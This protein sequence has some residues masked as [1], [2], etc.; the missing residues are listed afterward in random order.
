MV[1]EEPTAAGRE[2]SE[3]GYPARSGIGWRGGEDTEWLVPMR[4]SLSSRWSA[5]LRSKDSAS[6][7]KHEPDS[8]SRRLSEHV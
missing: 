6:S 7:K 3:S 5:S 8:Y 1:G 2:S 4:A